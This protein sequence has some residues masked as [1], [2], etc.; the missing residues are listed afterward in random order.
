MT[1]ALDFLGGFEASETALSQLRRQML[2]VSTGVDN[3]RAEGRRTFEALE[4][5]AKVL[6]SALV[7]ATDI[8]LGRHSA[9][10]SAESP[11]SPLQSAVEKV[12]S[13]AHATPSSAP[14]AAAQPSGHPLVEHAVMKLD[15]CKQALAAADEALASHRGSTAAN[16]PLTPPEHEIL[17]AAITSIVKPPVLGTL[18]ATP[19]PALIEH[20]LDHLPQ[21][22]EDS[23]RG[24]YAQE[25]TLR[26]LQSTRRDALVQWKEARAAL[27][28]ARAAAV[29]EQEEQEHNEH[30][31]VDRSRDSAHSKGG[32]SVSA[33]WGGLSPE[34]AAAK[35]RQ[36]AEWKASKDAQ[37]R[38]ERSARKEAAAKRMAAQRAA[39][40]A[41]AAERRE[42]IQ[43]FKAH[44]QAAA[45]AQ[46]KAAE[47][48]KAEQAAVFRP[49]KVSAA[50]KA[51]R[52]IAAAKRKAE[53]KR[54]AA[55]AAAQ[56]GARG[57]AALAVHGNQ[58]GVAPPAAPVLGEIRAAA[59]PGGA[60]RRRVV[61]ANPARVTAPTAAAAAR[62]QPPAAAKGGHGG[63]RGHTEAPLHLQPGVGGRRA[64]ALPSW[65]KVA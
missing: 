39:A 21:R 38:S 47:L 12:L 58:V 52:G 46:A 28:A 16:P 8:A 26:H 55:A 64:T 53:E 54:M 65:R 1:T 43:Q 22:A 19:P 63:Q 23:V 6:E 30:S 32:G 48:R 3:M 7:P 10:S 37:R 62:Q 45:A 49:P 11:S 25:A 33:G 4:R 56:A 13:P 35:R 2:H 27:A 17:L 31:G 5:E 57:V 51:K 29:A 61:P 50:A 34:Q 36:V 15:Q 59:V 40:A 9:Q 18:P 42:A 41:Q 14:P 60:M 44:K 20:V 24:A